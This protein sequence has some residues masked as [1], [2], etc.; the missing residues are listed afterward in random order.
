MKFIVGHPN[1]DTYLFVLPEPVIKTYSLD[2][3]NEV[4]KIVTHTWKSDPAKATQ[5]DT[6]QEARDHFTSPLCGLFSMEN[7][8]IV[9]RLPIN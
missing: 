8:C 6:F 3:I 2:D 7:G 1:F 4:E 5:F 9:D